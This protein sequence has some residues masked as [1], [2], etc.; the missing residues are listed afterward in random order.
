MVAKQWMWKVQYPNGVREI[1]ELHV[2]VG[3]PVKLTMASEDVIHSFFV[4]AFRLKRDVVPGR[5]NDMWFTA[6]K[7]GRYHLFCAEFCGT[8]HSGM[9][10]WVTVMEPK[11]FENWLATGGG[12]G[13]MASQG[14]KIFQQKGCSSCHLFDEQ[15]RCPNLKG[16]YG[17]RVL[18]ADGRTVVAD[19]A[20]IRDKILNPNGTIPMGF[21]KDIMPTFQGQVSEE[22][23]L[24]LTEYIKSLSET[25]GGMFTSEQTGPTAGGGRGGSVANAGQGSLDVHGTS[26]TNQPPRPEANAQAQDALQPA[27]AKPAAT[28]GKQ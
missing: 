2:P 13:S 14:Q 18:L 17:S 16:M 6:T 7:P 19:A 12:E 15:G 20:Y 25:R 10:G 8:E 24:E 28:G 21:A 5:Y 9:I 1:N 27:P 3:R 4:P 23:I 26:M 11:D 22:E